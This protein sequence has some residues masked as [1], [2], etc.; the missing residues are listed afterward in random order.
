MGLSCYLIHRDTHDSLLSCLAGAPPKTKQKKNKRMRN[1]SFL[2]LNIPLLNIL[3]YYGSKSISM[4][5]CTATKY[6][7]DMVG[8]DLS[9]DL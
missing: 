2:A 8:K 6:V 1:M 5:T 3:C 7:E 4:N 9:H